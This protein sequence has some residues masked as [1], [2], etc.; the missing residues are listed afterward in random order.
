MVTYEEL[1]IETRRDRKRNFKR[2]PR[3][4]FGS[5][6]DDEMIRRL[7]HEGI[8]REDWARA[9]VAA[10]KAVD[11]ATTHA[12]V[13]PALSIAIWVATAAIALGGVQIALTLSPTSTDP[14]ALQASGLAI[15]GFFVGAVA[16][17]A[18]GIWFATESRKQT[19]D[20]HNAVAW[21]C[22]LAKALVHGRVVAESAQPG[23]RD[24]KR[25]PG[26]FAWFCWPRSR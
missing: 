5:V 16:S 20:R 13:Q 25:S 19:A 11:D 7:V 12:M 24:G 22:A 26:L 23:M 15:I 17:V 9:S 3:V 14:R 18:L 4:L 8:D 10:D 6:C 2:T 21:R 1:R